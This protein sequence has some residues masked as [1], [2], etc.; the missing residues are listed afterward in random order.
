M[1]KHPAVTHLN[2][3]SYLDAQHIWVSKTGMGV[4]FGVNPDK[5]GGLGW[6]DQALERI[7]QRRKISVFTRHYQMPALLAQNVDLIA[8]LPTR[9]ARLQTQNPK[10]VIK[11][12]PFIFQI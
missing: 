3:K 7:G 4:G 8:T 6:I 12:P 10:L 11:D 5:Q 9:M 1:T 2:L